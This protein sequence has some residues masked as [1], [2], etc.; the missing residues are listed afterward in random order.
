M[1]CKDYLCYTTDSDFGIRLHEVSGYF[2]LQE[3]G[4]LPGQSK[5]PLL[6]IF[7]RIFVVNIFAKI[8]WTMIGIVIAWICAFFIANLLQCWPIAANWNFTASEATNCVHTTRM[9]LGQAWSDVFTDG[10]FCFC[11]SKRFKLM[12]AKRSNYSVD[13]N[14]LCKF[15]LA[16]F[17]CRG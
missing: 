12:S 7:N 4:D 1:A 11:F 3:V 16:Y 13:A 6:T 9:Y 10:E 14:S 5:I 15:P 2:F 17:D 8:S